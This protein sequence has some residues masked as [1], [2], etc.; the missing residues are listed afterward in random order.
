MDELGEPH[1]KKN[2]ALPKR[3][4][5]FQIFYLKKNLYRCLPK[6]PKC[7]QQG[8]SNCYL[9]NAQIDTVFLTVGL[10]LCCHDMN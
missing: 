5:R 3:G 4:K 2:W 1:P 6:V 8:G 10:P 7:A 9:G